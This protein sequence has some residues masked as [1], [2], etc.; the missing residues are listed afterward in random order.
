MFFGCTWCAISP[1][2]RTTKTKMRDTLSSDSSLKQTLH[3]HCFHHS[4]P[5]PKILCAT[6]NRLGII[7][8]RT[9]LVASLKKKDFLI[10]C[11]QSPRSSSP[12]LVGGRLP[13]STRVVASAMDHLAS[14]PWQ[15][16]C[17]SAP[18]FVP[19]AQFWLTNSLHTTKNRGK[20]KIW[21]TS[22]FEG[23][24]EILKT[25]FMVF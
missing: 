22:I 6:K 1:K 10:L 15:L 19:I 5:S 3:V 21:D 17:N 16:I 14:F 2:L 12:S 9:P 13:F 23:C 24:V 18:W 4:L 11:I 20:K 7:M 25:P 8:A